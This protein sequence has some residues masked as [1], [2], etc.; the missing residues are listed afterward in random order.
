MA[1]ISV[2]EWFARFARSQP[3]SIELAESITQLSNIR[4]KRHFMIDNPVDIQLHGFSDASYKGYGAVV[5]IR[6]TDIYGNI[7]SHIVC[8]KSRIAPKEIRST[9]RLE[10]CGAVVLAHVMKLVEKSLNI[11]LQRNSA[12]VS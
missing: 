1:H 6:S 7:E 8:A 5:Y 4:I 10:L 9:P 2:I 12:N 3:V 11:P